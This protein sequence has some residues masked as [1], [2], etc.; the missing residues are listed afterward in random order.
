MQPKVLDLNALVTDME[1]LLERLIREDVEFAFVPGPS[2]GSVKAD[3]GQIEQV[4]LNLTVNACDAMPRGGKLTIETANLTVDEKYALSRPGLE[5]GSFVLLAATDSG[6]GMDAKTKAR[7]FEPFFTTK[8]VGKGTGLGLST[9]YGIIKQSG[10][11]IWVDSAPGKGTRFKVYLPRVNEQTDPSDSAKYALPSV[12]GSP[13]ILVVEDDATVRE[14]AIRFLNSAGYRVRAAKDGVEAL[15]LAK[16]SRDPIS[17]LLTDIVKP[18]MRGTELAVWLRDLIPQIEVVF[19]SGYIEYN[20]ESHRLMAAWLYLEKPFTR[21]T[22]LRKMQESLSTS[23]AKP[24]AAIKS[25]PD[26]VRSTL[27]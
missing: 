3:P 16:H 6:Y 26:P 15:A 1:K 17:A 2:L 20:E 18:N 13:T 24:V 5:Q 23:M 7:I 11:F 12:A 27:V 19:M 10:G 9:V 25:T 14:L 8:D 21:E 4:L 22:L